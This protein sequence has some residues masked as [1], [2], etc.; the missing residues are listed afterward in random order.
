[1]TDIPFRDRLF[2]SINEAAEATGTS[3][4]KVYE[5]LRAGT[6]RG[7][8]IDEGGRTKILV[9][10]LLELAERAKPADD[11]PGAVASSGPAA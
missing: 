9:A 3:R 4:A 10:S 11:A 7:V 8:R 2:C 1:M 6:V 5:W